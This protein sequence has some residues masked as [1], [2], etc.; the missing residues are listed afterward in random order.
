MT[1]SLELQII[2]LVSA[3]VFAATLG[4][5]AYLTR[6][7]R[8][9]QRLRGLH[10]GDYENFQQER[11]GVVRR[12]LRENFDE[13]FLSNDPAAR[14]ELRQTLIRAGFFSSDAVWKYYLIRGALVLVIP[15]LGFLYSTQVFAGAGLLVHVG[16][17]IFLFL[18]ALIAPSAYVNRRQRKL[19]EEYRIV[20]PDMLDW[21][22]VSVNS[23]LSL[24]AAVE[25][26]SLE[27][28]DL[29]PALGLNLALVTAELRAGR[30]TIDSLQGFAERT[31]IEEAKSFVT[32]LR[33]SLELGTSVSQTLR[34][35]AEEMRDK[36]MARAEQR[37]AELPVKM[38]LP[39]AGLIFPTILIILMLPIALRF[40]GLG[41]VVGGS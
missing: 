9:R 16:A 28:S 30:T 7:S 29:S 34:V 3:A 12:F 38:T 6:R 41:D 39:L 36:R 17:A 27:V 10:S 31:G 24:E 14:S 1:V 33:Q 35:Y 21:F 2:L 26:I 11:A 15:P 40:I 18:L 23:G 32:L 20:F 8:L 13:R 4:I 25:R 22:L 5:Y 19:A 37:A